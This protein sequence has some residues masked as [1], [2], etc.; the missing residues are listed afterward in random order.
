M[1]GI[2]AC[3]VLILIITALHRR[4]GGDIGGLKGSGHT[5]AVIVCNF[6][7]ENDVKSGFAELPLGRKGDVPR[8]HGGG[9]RGVPTG[10]G[11]ARFGG[12][13]DG[14]GRAITGIDRLK[15]VTA[16][17]IELHQ[18]V[19]AVVVN[20]DFRAAVCRDLGVSNI[21]QRIEAGKFFCKV[22]T[23]Q[24]LGIAFFRLG[25]CQRILRAGNILLIVLNGE[26]NQI[27]RVCNGIRLVLADRRYIDMHGFLIRFIANNDGAG[28]IH[29]VGS[30]RADSSRP[31]VGRLR[32]VFE[33]IVDNDAVGRGGNIVRPLVCGDLVAHEVDA[34]LGG[35]LIRRSSVRGQRSFSR[36]SAI[37]SGSC[38]HGAL[39]GD[40]GRLAD[41]LGLGND[42][43]GLR[44]QRRGGDGRFVRDLHRDG[45]RIGH[46]LTHGETAA[47]IRRA[48]VQQIRHERVAGFQLHAGGTGNVRPDVAADL[49]LPLIEAGAGC[50]NRS[51][52]GLLIFGKDNGVRN[53]AILAVN[54]EVVIRRGGGNERRRH[55]A[56]RESAAEEQR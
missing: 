21:D 44:S 43:R 32:S 37:C 55:E 10:K 45:V 23:D 31:R 5:V 4:A 2:S 7:P 51:E 20:L 38:F 16:I 18:I 53:S 27:G 33:N 34:V 54:K 8:G 11:I 40:D 48:A 24:I 29:G 39:R 26:V 49:D 9:K 14:D 46:V 30:S 56:E 17:Q 19:V 6:I 50:G 52:R 13:T 41:S 15:T 47:E 36:R 42:G 25:F 3:E 35:S 12:F 1:L 22:C 28:D